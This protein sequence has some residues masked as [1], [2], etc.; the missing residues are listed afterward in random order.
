MFP[1][2]QAACTF[3]ASR[4]KAVIWHRPWQ[5][6]NRTTDI[7]NDTAKPAKLYELAGI[8]DPAEFYRARYVSDQLLDGRYF[9][10]LNRFDILWAHTIWIYDNVRRRAKVLDVGC[11]SGRLALLKRKS[12]M[13][14]GVDLSKECA[15]QARRNGYDE[16]HAANL[17]DL[18]FEN[19]T[20]DYVVSLD[21]MGHV[22]VD[23]KD[24]VLSEL[25]RV[26]KADGVTLHG[27]EVMNRARRKDYDQMNES[28][29]RQFV[30]IDGHVGMESESAIRE[31][32]SRF[33]SHLQIER[34]HSICQSAEELM[35][36]AD[37]YGAQLCD[38]D[39]LSYLRG[40]SFAE[41][42]AFNMAMGFV[43][44]EINEQDAREP[45]AKS[46]YLFLKA[47][48]SPLGSFY[49]EHYDRSDLFPRAIY[50]QSGESASLDETMAAEF[51]AG[52]YE[53]EN[54]PPIGRWM[55]ARAGIRFVANA[56]KK[57][58]FDITTH[59]PDAR[60]RPVRLQFLLNGHQLREVT[61]AE[62]DWQKIELDA[63][64]MASH[65][66]QPVVHEFEIRAD[67]T[68][69]PSAVDVTSNDDRQLSVALGSLRI[70]G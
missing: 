22:A 54:F 37:E 57:I 41:R 64:M 2:A 16:A 1:H 68:W 60:V 32:W 38:P 51:D 15:E 11:G 18:P 43:F 12:V 20:F 24:A 39:F 45:A 42:R 59:L 9:S 55:G 29:L 47:S 69:Q 5:F 67:R 10:A 49:R 26:L 30:A 13:L 34:R 56:F 14:I 62:N 50:L 33:F 8:D 58:C 63:T 17:I 40:L 28:E 31:R 48:A 35:K 19:S 66:S 65:A 61:L 25:C 52:W 70:I 7:L 6:A 27:I 46:E 23:Q 44:N 21:V 3:T 53:A 36:Q 4:T